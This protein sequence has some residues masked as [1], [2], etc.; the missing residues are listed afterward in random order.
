MHRHSSCGI[1]GASVA[2]WG[3]TVVLQQAMMTQCMRNHQKCNGET[4]SW[5]GVHRALWRG[6]QEADAIIDYT[7]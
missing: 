6:Y 7:L 1:N 4:Y 3:S 5:C 2:C